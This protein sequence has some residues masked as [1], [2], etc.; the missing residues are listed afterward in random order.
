MSNERLVAVV[1]ALV[2]VSNSPLQSFIDHNE[3]KYEILCVHDHII[4]LIDI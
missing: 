3:G 4:N 1:S 2:D